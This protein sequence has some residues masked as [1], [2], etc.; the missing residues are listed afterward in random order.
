M[1][2]APALGLVVLFLPAGFLAAGL[3]AP[4]SAAQAGRIGAVLPTTNALSQAAACMESGR[5]AE[6]LALFDGIL[7]RPRNDAEAQEAL[8][9]KGRCWNQA[10]QYRKA[11][12]CYDAFLTAYKGSQYAD[13]ALLRAGVIHVGP[14][15]DAARGARLYTTILERYPDSNAAETALYHLATLAFWDRDWERARALYRRVLET[16][17][18]GPY[19]RFLMG[20]RLPALERVIRAKPERQKEPRSCVKHGCEPRSLSGY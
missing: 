12:R 7:H 14:L 9:Q 13:D 10:R 16:W 8:F 18:E 11:L 17:P 19:A 20:E 1:N 2:P 6:A 3:A 15:H 5:P 4:L